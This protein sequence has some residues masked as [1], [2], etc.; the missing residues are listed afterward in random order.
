MGFHVFKIFPEC[1]TIYNVEGIIKVKKQHIKLLFFGYITEW[2]GHVNSATT[3]LETTIWFR[4]NFIDDVLDNTVQ[5][6]SS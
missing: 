3:R 1:F 2:V 5:S 4:V 6:Q